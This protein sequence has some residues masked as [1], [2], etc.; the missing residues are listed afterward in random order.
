MHKA[1]T[2][3]VLVVLLTAVAAGVA[4]ALTTTTCSSVPCL[5]TP[6]ADVLNERVGDGKRD[7]IYGGRGKDRIWAVRD[8][9]D[10]DALYG[11]RGNDRL[12]VEDRD[13]KDRAV[14]GP[15][16]RDVCFIDEGREGSFRTCEIVGTS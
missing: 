6:S 9:A 14:G 8:G 3:V 12:N 2:M 10:T 16:K 1:T 11:G 15:G 5:G 13:F 7:V 4:F